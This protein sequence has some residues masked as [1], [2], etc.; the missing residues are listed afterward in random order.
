MANEA[1]AVANAS[2]TDDD[3]DAFEALRPV[4]AP[5]TTDR[6]RRR[7]DTVQEAYEF[8]ASAIRNQL[9]RS[10]EA[11]PAPNTAIPGDAYVRRAFYTL[12]SDRRQRRLF[13]ATATNQRAWPRLRALFG[14]PPY[15]FLKAEDAGV[16]RAAGIAPSRVNMS[17]DEAKVACSSAQFGDGHLEDEHD[18]RYRVVRVAEETDDD[19][20][21]HTFA[22]LDQPYCVLHVKLKRVKRRQGTEFR[23]RAAERRAVEFPRKGE[24]VRL[25]P[26]RG[27]SALCGT[28]YHRASHAQARACVV[29]VIRTVVRAPGARTAGLL[30]S[31][32]APETR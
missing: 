21:A 12:L 4:P 5:G 28:P 1:A 27:M 2:D 9:D 7:I 20:L 16:L 11:K 18:R 31:V 25:A 3:D 22:V 19:P 32:E 14:A 17:F 13:L 30:V 24:R 10:I 26:T 6:R 15:G 29:T 23:S 8:V